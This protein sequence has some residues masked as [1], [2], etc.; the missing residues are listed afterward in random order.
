MSQQGEDVRIALD[1]LLGQLEA[2]G[3]MWAYEKE[4]VVVW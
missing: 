3:V 4:G 2:L 1:T